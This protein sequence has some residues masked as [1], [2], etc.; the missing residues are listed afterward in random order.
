MEPRAEEKE[1][2]SPVLHE[3]ERGVG[4]SGRIGE[5]GREEAG[6]AAVVDSL[7]QGM[8]SRELGCSLPA[9]HGASRRSSK[10][11]FEQAKTVRQELREKVSRLLGRTGTV[12]R[13]SQ[14]SPGMYTVRQFQNNLAWAIVSKDTVRFDELLNKYLDCCNEGKIVGIAGRTSPREKHENTA[15]DSAISVSVGN[16]RSLVDRVFHHETGYTMT[17]LVVVSGIESLLR[18]CL[19]FGSAV[20]RY[21]DLNGDTALTLALWLQPEMAF[22]MLELG[23]DVDITRIGARGR[24]LLHSAVTL[25]QETPPWESRLEFIQRIVEQ[26]N[27]LA[28]QKDFFGFTPA[29][30][31][32]ENAAYFS[33]KKECMQIVEFLRGVDAAYRE[34]MK[35]VCDAQTT[36]GDVELERI[37]SRGKES[38]QSRTVHRET[39]FLDRMRFIFEGPLTRLLSIAFLLLLHIFLYAVDVA[40]RGPGAQYR[41][42]RWDFWFTGFNNIASCW[43]GS[44]FFMGMTHAGCAFGCALLGA[45]VY[46]LVFHMLFGRIIMRLPICGAQS[47]A[48]WRLILKS[49]GDYYFSGDVGR[50]RG[51]CFAMAIGGVLGIYGGAKLYNALLYRFWPGQVS[52]A[53]IRPIISGVDTVTALRCFWV[54]SLFIDWY[55]F[56]FVFDIMYQQGS[57]N[58]YLPHHTFGGFAAS[59]NGACF[60]KRKKQLGENNILALRMGIYWTLLI[61]GWTVIAAVFLTLEFLCGPAKV[62]FANPLIPVTSLEIPVGVGCL[63][64]LLEFIIVA[65]EWTW[66][67]F[68]GHPHLFFP[69]MV[70]ATHHVF[71]LVLVL[72][73]QCS[74]DI[75]IVL[76]H[77]LLLKDQEGGLSP[78]GAVRLCI[79]LIP[80]MFGV[81]LLLL[82]IVRSSLWWEMCGTVGNAI[83]LYSEHMYLRPCPPPSEEVQR[84]AERENEKFVR[85]HSRSL[86]CKAEQ[87]NM[88]EKL[89]VRK[90]IKRVGRQIHAGAKERDGLLR[91]EKR[92]GDRNTT[93]AAAWNNPS[94]DDSFISLS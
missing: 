54:T 33:S 17:H 92:H 9:A 37:S 88:K 46:L 94:S 48:E 38:D 72:I 12:V 73:V 8:S 28:S 52:W 41:D 5:V 68:Q 32:L 61:F 3:K 81:I 63:C 71:F 55:I 30:W 58:I 49:F 79:A 70:V 69:G 36:S 60:W 50:Q 76:A 10:G 91:G 43:N 90:A 6:S 29:E 62:L 93:A 66:P 80:A 65:Q 89:R 45:C 20:H 82:V 1:E 13:E 83:G 16:E 11:M 24:N 2:C 42:A 74:L 35:R 25:R 85:L 19:A 51:V 39:L 67:T 4:Q 15:A 7:Q 44:A 26:D 23:K 77:I 31:A 53:L 14:H 75:R 57:L 34:S 59:I 78:K 87:E 21:E 84:L 18:S 27:S 64:I 86:Y 56:M 40:D 22:A 47:P